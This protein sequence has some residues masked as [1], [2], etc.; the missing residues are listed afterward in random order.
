M[1]E[2]GVWGGGGGGGGGG[3]GERGEWLKKN[4]DVNTCRQVTDFYR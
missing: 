4:A 3:E 2:K 1:F